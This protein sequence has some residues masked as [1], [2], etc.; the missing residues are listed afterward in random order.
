M[1]EDYAKPGYRKIHLDSSIHCGYDNPTKLL[2]R[3]H[4]AERAAS[5]CF[6]A[7]QAAVDDPKPRHKPMYVIGSEVPSPGG[8]AIRDHM[9]PREHQLQLSCAQRVNLASALGVWNRNLTSLEPIPLVRGRNQI[10]DASFRAQII[11]SIPKTQ[12]S[13][14]K[15]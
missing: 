10:S 4:I 6:I 3:R 14:R 11:S 1:V 12:P 13:H 15:N 9:K 8:L 5:L 7:E 2:N